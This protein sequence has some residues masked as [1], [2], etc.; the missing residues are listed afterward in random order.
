MK[1]GDAF[2][3]FRR[4]DETTLVSFDYDLNIVIRFKKINVELSS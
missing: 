3:G 2:T 4:E 1:A